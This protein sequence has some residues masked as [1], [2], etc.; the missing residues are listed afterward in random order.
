MS[1]ITD[2][3][4]VGEV[5]AVKLRTAGVRTTEALLERG[6]TPQGRRE[7]AKMTGFS[8]KVIL[9]WVNRADMF[10]VRGI[11][12][13]YSDLLEAAGVDTVRELATRKAETLMESLAKANIEKNKV[14]KLPGLS[15]VKGWIQTAKTLRKGVEY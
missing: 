14:N 2:I 5:S 10:R 11:G 1:T 4:G 8:E 13:Q 7:L 9:E 3:E 12:S 6:R 15:R